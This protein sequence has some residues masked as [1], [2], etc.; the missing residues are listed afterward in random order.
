MKRFSTVVCLLTLFLT[1]DAGGMTPP[2]PPLSD[3][4]AKVLFKVTYSG[5]LNGNKE[6]Q[7][8]LEEKKKDKAFVKKY[9]NPGS[10]SYYWNILIERKYI[11]V[12]PNSEMEKVYSDLSDIE[13]ET[14]GCRLKRTGVVLSVV[15]A[16]ALLCKGFSKLNSAD[17]S[18][19]CS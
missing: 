15:A 12:T 2:D 6:F 16:V 4:E 14:L 13:R 8:K 18:Y 5:A 7:H 19:R 1:S 11:G 3:A 10:I 17:Y 9:G